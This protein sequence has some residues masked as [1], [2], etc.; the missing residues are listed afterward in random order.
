M[1]LFIAL[2]LFAA[3]YVYMLLRTTDT[4]L[5]QAQHI[6][7]TYQFVAAHSDQLATGR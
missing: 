7:Q 6:N 2:T 4:V 1:K 5:S 3:G